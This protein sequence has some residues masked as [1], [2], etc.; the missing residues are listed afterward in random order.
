MSLEQVSSVACFS[1]YHFHRIF[2]A[3]VGETLGQFIQR[4]RVEKAA[5]MLIVNPK[6]SIT[7]I[8]L[9]CGFGS[10]A[11]FARVFG[12]AYGMSASAWRSGGYKQ[13]RKIRKTDSKNGKTDSKN[14][15][16]I[17]SSS[18]YIDEHVTNSG[19]DCSD[20]SSNRFPRRNKMGTVKNV[21]VEV[22]DM[23]EMTVAYV[24][25]IGPYK[26]NSKLFEGLWGR[27]MKWA[28]PRGLLQ[29][30]DLKCLSVYHDDPGITDEQNLRTSVCISVRPDTKVDGEVGK[31]SIPAGKYASAHFEINPDEYQ[32]AWDYVF[33]TWLPDSGYQPDDRP[34]FELCLN[35]PKQHP[36][37]KHVVDICVPVRPL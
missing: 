34:C 20:V 15:K 28:G 29:Q 5:S 27:L 16:E 13:N 6:K 1:P 7:E 25:H 9:D 19:A 35:D 3:I 23:P 21:K 37:H 17:S 26:G 2:R 33:G 8:A 32:Q 18:G 11:A 31:M 4:V 22:K 24:R 12:E 10:S 14:R 30:P 36:E